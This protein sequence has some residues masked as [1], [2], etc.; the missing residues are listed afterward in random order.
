[1][2]LLK[3]LTAYLNDY[4][5]VRDVPDWK[6]ALNGLQVEGR[7]EIGRVAVAVDACLATIERAV[8]E[9]ADLM[10]VHHGLFWG[11][12][13]PITGPYYRR[14]AAL[15]KN[16]LALYSCHTPLDAHPEVGN[17]HVLARM[18]GLEPAG[19][20]GEYEGVPLGVWT[21][22]EL[23]REAFVERVRQ[24]LGVVPKV[25]ATG[26]QTVRRVGI[27]TGGG[28]SWIDRAAALG[29]D[30]FL[31]GEGA[32][33]TYFDAEERGLNVLYAGHYATETVGVRALGNHLR[34]RFGLATFFID[35]P[36][37]L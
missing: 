22:T 10:I 24:A 2:L 5:A 20:F 36:T 26:P 14:L 3:E 16:D 6:D 13:A 7:Q 21:E 4:L 8:S 33:H 35:H 28:G 19:R 37:G 29:L 25:I 23:P 1:M 18:L 9:Q 30:T 34:E 12:K 27:L 11:P 32:H 15:I 31:T 17:N